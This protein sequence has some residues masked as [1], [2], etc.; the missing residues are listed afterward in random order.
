MLLNAYDAKYKQV[1]IEEVDEDLR[2]ISPKPVSTVDQFKYLLGRSAK[3]TFRNSSLLKSKLMLALFLGGIYNMLYY[4]LDTSR[5]GVQNRNGLFFML[6][7]TLLS[8]GVLQVV[9]T[10]P[11]H[12]AVFI[13]EQGFQ[14]YGSFAYFWAKILPETLME[15]VIPTLFFLFLYWIEGLNTNSIEKP[16]IFWGICLLAHFAGGSLGFMLGSILTNVQAVSEFTVLTFFPDSVYSGF[17][18]NYASIPIPFKYLTYLSSF[19]YAFSAI[20]QNE[21]DGLDFECEDDEVDPCDP[22]DDLSIDIPMWLNIVLLAAI[23]IVYRLLAGVFLK[24]YAKKI[25]S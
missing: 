5:K 25:Y 18:V 12:R 20:A 14:M 8:S 13:K 15:A 4:N 16:L 24:L 3:E 2:N 1:K 22:L 9:L 10:F 21:Y 7:I 23:V 6:I 11:L 17:L 19:R